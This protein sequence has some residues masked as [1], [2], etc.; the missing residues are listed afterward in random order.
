MTV[1]N[2]PNWKSLSNSLKMILFSAPTVKNS[3][4]YGRHFRRIARGKF[5]EPV[6]ML[7]FACAAI[8]TTLT[9]AKAD[10]IDYGAG[11]VNSLAPT[12]GT[13]IGGTDNYNY[14]ALADHQGPSGVPV[15]GIGVGCFDYNPE[16]A[17]TRICINNW[18]ASDQA[19]AGIIHKA[20]GTFLAVWRDG[21]TQLL[22]R[23]ESQAGI[24]PAAHTVYRGLF[25]V[26]ECRV[27]DAATVRCWSGLVPQDVRD[28]S[29]PLAWIEVEVGNSTAA[30]QQVAV[31]FSWQDVIGRG[32]VDVSNLDL[33]KRGGATTWGKE[34]A[35]NKADK[36]GQKTWTFLDRVS[37]Q[38][39]AFT[40]GSLTGVRQF[41]APLHPILNTYQNYNNEV[42]VLAENSGGTE[43][44]ILPGYSVD[45]AGNAWKSFRDSGH[46]D[47]ATGTVPLF[48]PEAKREMASAVAIRAT[49]KPGEKRVFRF[50]VAWFQPQLKPQGDPI[51]YF[52]KADYGRYFHNYF[53]SLPQLLDYAAQNRERIRQGT[54][55]WHQPILASTYPD[56][57]KFKLINSAYTLYANTILNKAGDF[58]VMEGGMNG[59]AGTM[60]QRLSAHPFYF[61]FFTALDRSDLEMFGLNPGSEGQ[62]LHFNGHYY[63]GIDSR[64]GETPVP[65]NC[66]VDNSGG[67]LVQLA[68]DWQQH[69]DLAWIKQFDGEIHKSIAYLRARIES[70]EFQ[71][72][73]GSTTYDDFWHPE[74]YAYNASTYPVFLRAG[75]VLLDALGDHEGANACREQA[76]VSA[77]D[78]IRALWNGNFFAYGADLDGKNRR[79]D[80]MFSGQLAGQFLSRYCGWGDV[81]PMDLVRKSILSQLKSNIA[82]SPDY[83]APKVWL[84]KDGKAMRDPRRPNDPNANSTC[85]PFYLESYT[86]MA[87]IQAG[88]VDDGLEIMRHIQL[89]N[90]RNGWTW[91]QDLW[92]PGELTYVC[93]PVTWFITDVLAGTALDIPSKTLFL[94]PVLRPSDDKLVLPVYF[95]R[96]WATVTV[97]RKGH[98]LALQ[99]TRTF[100]DPNFT[101]EHVIAQPVGRPTSELRTVDIPPFNVRDGAVLD[102]SAYWDKLVAADVQGAVLGESTPRQ[103]ALPLG[104]VHS[105]ESAP[106]PSG[107]SIIITGNI[108]HF[109]T[110]SGVKVEGVPN[111]GTYN[112]EVYGDSFTAKAAGLPAGTYTIEIDFAELFVQGPGKRVMKI[113][114]GDNVLADN[115]DLFAVAG[116]AKPYKLQAKVDHQDDALRGPLAITFTGIKDNA[117]FNAIHIFDAEGKE[118][119][120]V[121]AGDLTA[122][123]APL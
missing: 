26:A 85:W 52:G 3:T 35:F 104:R 74:I 27:D 40:V 18:H 1:D 12:A 94:A 60:D 89:V 119:A 86:A 81:F 16:G 17:F 96:F 33:L 28:S 78:A 113:T 77:N 10:N 97:D 93:A 51:T 59:L 91:T 90:L 118:V 87:A 20:P 57:L 117:K 120:S 67:W 48:S 92:Q 63:F 13:K 70:K 11:K 114:S 32:I 45:D 109:K 46:F 65:D 44:T 22:Q 73:T 54:L 88:Y 69:G 7:A 47:K 103:L 4:L 80:I 58:T 38:A 100:G 106:S 76:V 42:A 6:A 108:T 62:I 84:V 24:Q 41:S 122:Y 107:K 37:T 83:Y 29:L 111:D 21:K 102:L 30:S 110:P 82:G 2:N 43:V 19:D 115:L 71:I 36:A 23:G 14:L 39:G 34:E 101:I 95:P 75:G 8:F 72:I 112:E 79:D 53:Q 116:F 55:S 99:V 61:K 121:K 15:G 66:M 98:Q 49:L 68:K 50:A 31:A 5:T 64:D 25:P 9:G 123:T 105:D 56:W